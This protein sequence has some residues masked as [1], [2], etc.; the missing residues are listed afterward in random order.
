MRVYHM[1]NTKDPRVLLLCI[2]I[3]EPAE[4]RPARNKERYTGFIENRSLLLVFF[5]P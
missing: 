1:L 5:Y 2:S 3:R 4:E